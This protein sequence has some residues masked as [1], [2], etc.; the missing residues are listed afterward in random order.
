M[1]E[2]YKSNPSQINEVK[3][4]KT[5]DIDGDTFINYRNGSIEIFKKENDLTEED[6]LELSWR[7]TPIFDE[8]KKYE[9][10]KLDGIKAVNQMMSELRVNSI[11]NGYPREINRTIE[12]AFDGVSYNLVTYG[13][14]ISA[15]EECNLVEI[16]GYVTQGLKDRIKLVLETYIAA[17]Y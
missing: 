3:F 6:R 10:R 17:N 2:K 8:V 12:K 5:I 16:N 1:S 14:W 13:W 15:L 11:Q 9:T 4:I 7:I